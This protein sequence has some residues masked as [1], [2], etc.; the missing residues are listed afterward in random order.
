MNRLLISRYLSFFQALIKIAVNSKIA[1][2]TRLSNTWKF[3]VKDS[4]SCIVN[5]FY[6]SLTGVFEGLRANFL[7]SSY[8]SMNLLLVRAG[9]IPFNKRLEASSKMKQASIPDAGY[10]EHH[11]FPKWHWVKVLKICRFRIFP[12]PIFRKKI[13]CRSC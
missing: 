12:C 7:Q 1:P 13:I 8:F 2:G 5:F 4:K 3:H 11:K 9:K 6:C 10:E